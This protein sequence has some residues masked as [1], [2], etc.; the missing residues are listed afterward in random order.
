MIDWVCVNQVVRIFWLS[1]MV[2]ATD[3][4]LRLHSLT[5]TVSHASWVVTVGQVDRQGRLIVIGLHLQYTNC[6]SA[7]FIA[8]TVKV[9]N[10]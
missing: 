8:Y 10:Y 5:H 7:R 6:Y 9:H 1:T 4:L 3:W 2:A